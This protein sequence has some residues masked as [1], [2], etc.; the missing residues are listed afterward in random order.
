MKRIAAFLLLLIMLAAVTS[1][2]AVKASCPAGGFS[3]KLP[4]GFRE[5]SFSSSDDPDLCFWWSGNGLAIQAYAVYLGEVA[6]SDLFQVLT[7]N[8]SESGMTSVNGISMLYAA[9]RDASG[10][11]MMYSWMDRGNNVTLYFCATGGDAS[12]LSGVK[13]IM[14]TIAFDAGH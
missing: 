5:H 3:L 4:D 9:G 10:P 11:Y 8:E 12:A 13:K 14:R 6:G 7:G 2:C 1:A